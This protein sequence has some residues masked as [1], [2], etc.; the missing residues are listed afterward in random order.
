MGIVTHLVVLLGKYNVSDMV[1]SFDVVHHSILS[2]IRWCLPLCIY[3][4][5]ISFQVPYS[6]ESN[7]SECIILHLQASS[8]LNF[9]FSSS[10]FNL[11]SFQS[12]PSTLFSIFIFFNL[13]QSLSSSIFIFFNL[14]NS[15]QVVSNT[16]LIY[17]ASRASYSRVGRSL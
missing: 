8:P 13:Y 12:S 4:F 2:V 11:S 7:R 6:E 5:Y 10:F 3:T 15:F 14:F 9:S 17:S 1:R 16:P